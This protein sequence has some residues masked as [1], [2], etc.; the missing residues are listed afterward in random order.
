MK[1]LGPEGALVAVAVARLVEDVGTFT[2]TV[3]VRTVVDVEAGTL[4]ARV[5]DTAG[6]VPGTHWSRSRPSAR[7]SLILPHD[8]M[9]IGKNSQYHGFCEEQ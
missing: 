6:A 8:C 5:E 9:L 1:Y 4:V 7:C 2:V 3:V